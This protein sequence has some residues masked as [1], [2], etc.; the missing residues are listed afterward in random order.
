MT[1]GVV[2]RFGGDEFVV[3][4]AL[5]DVE[6]SSTDD[7]DDIGSDPNAA[8]ACW[9]NNNWRT[10]SIGAHFSNKDAT[11]DQAL[12]CADLALFEAKANGRN[13]IVEY[14]ADLIA[15]RDRRRL[16]EARVREAVRDDLFGVAYQPLAIT[17]VPRMLSALKLF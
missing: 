12:H 1:K 10:A 7:P 16:I 4:G 14:T 15:K 17:P 13:Q 11:A 2:G 6:G 9:T 8:G 3:A 5:F